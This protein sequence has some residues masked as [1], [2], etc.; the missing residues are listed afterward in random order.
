MA[1]TEKGIIYPY[2]Y[3]EVADVPSDFKALAESIDRILSDY[4]LNTESG[5]KIVLEMNNTTYKIKAVLKDKDDN[6]ISTSNEIDLPLEGM[7]TNIS[8]NNQ[9]LTLTHQDGHTTEVSIADLISDLASKEEVEDLQSQVD[10]LTTLVETELD[11]NTVEGTEIDISDSAE[12]R[13]PLMPG[14][15]LEQEQLSG[16]NKIDSSKIEQITANG[17]T[18][19]YNSETQ[20]ITFN[21]TCTTDN[22]LFQLLNTQMQVTK[23]ITRVTAYYIRGSVTNYCSL[24][25]FD[26][27][28]GS[29]IISSLLTLPN[30][31]IISNIYNESFVAVHNN[32]RFNKNSVCN[33][34]T[35]KIMMADDTDITYEPYCGEQA[36]PNPDYPQEIKVVTG[37]NVVNH[38]GKNLLNIADGTYANNGVTAVVENGKITLNGTP[39]NGT[40][41]IKIPFH[42]EYNGLTYSLS[43]NNNE[44]LGGKTGS[45][46]CA[47][48]R[49]AGQATTQAVLGNKNATVTF[50]L[51]DTYNDITIRTGYGLTYNNFV[52]YPQLEI[53]QPTPYEPHREEEYELSLGNI[54][55]CKTDDHEDI[56]FKNEV[57]DENYNA[58]LESGAWYKKGVIDKKVLDDS[59]TWFNNATNRFSVEITAPDGDYIL[60][61]LC[62][63]YIN[64]LNWTAHTNTDKSFIVRNGGWG[65]NKCRI[66]FLDSDY[67][68]LAEWTQFVSENN[69]IVYHRL[70]NPTY[71]KIT[72]PTLISQLEALKKAKWFKGVNHWWTETENLEPVLKG[73]YKQSNNLRLQALEQAVVALGGV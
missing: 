20:E 65:A 17:I 58:E 18:C 19:S 3:N 63:K 52:L 46:N 57:G 34:F 23:N 48:L 71:E 67:A 28:Y 39:I 45:E 61:A 44:V 42:Y 55:L 70:L 59:W 49:I 21:G 5:N 10:D 12:Y 64:A 1:Q 38:I 66:S 51:D 6:V 32:F 27:N 30:D 73:T 4:S 13:G 9:T 37:D 69:L 7:V 50:V 53:G 54:E 68:S 22:T 11:S 43:A 25:F 16:K 8:Y 26:S 29:G 35:I 40:S 41:F 15:N 31:K 60:S 33:D 62:D 72:D 14:A 47:T 36:S 2:D 56:S 24:R